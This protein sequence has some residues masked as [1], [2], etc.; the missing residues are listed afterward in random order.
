M[1]TAHYQYCGA[2]CNGLVT[3]LE[4]ASGTRLFN[5]DISFRKHPK[6]G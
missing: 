3:D 6:S 1:T 5:H 2:P 4:I